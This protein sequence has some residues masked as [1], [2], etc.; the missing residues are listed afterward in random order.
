MK[1]LLWL[2]PIFALWLILKNPMTFKETALTQTVNALP[3]CD[4]KKGSVYDG[5]TLRVL[6]KGEETKIRFACIDAPELKQDKGIASRDHLRSLLNKVNNRVKVQATDVD[7]YGRTVAELYTPSNQSIPVQQAKDGWVWA[8]GK[9]KSDCP[10][11][12]KVEA[13]E[14]EARAAKRGIWN[15]NPMPPW[16]WRRRNR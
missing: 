8:N 7:R 4:V 1:K 5:D 10:S 16:E 14:Q 13:A 15:G 6:C 3:L 12:D 9:Y 11:W 2:V